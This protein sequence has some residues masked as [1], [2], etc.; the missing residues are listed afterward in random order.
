MTTRTRRQDLG[1][2]K[3]K[4]QQRKERWQRKLTASGDASSRFAVKADWF[5]SSVRL[6]IHRHTR[7]GG[8]GLLAVADPRALTQAD[9]LLDYAGDLLAQLAARLDGGGYDQP[10]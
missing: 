9:Q 1:E 5:R 7:P 3:T 10:R 2:T 6:M 8:L 4:A